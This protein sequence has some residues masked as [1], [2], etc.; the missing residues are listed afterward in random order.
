MFVLVQLLTAS[1]IVGVIPL[2]WLMEAGY[3]A[4]AL[5]VFVALALTDAIDG[6]LAR[7]YDCVSDWGK[8][9][10]PMA[11]K[12]FLLATLFVL[13]PAAFLKVEFSILVAIEAVL[14][15]TSFLAYTFPEHIGRA[16]GANRSGKYKAFGEIILTAVLLGHAVGF[17]AVSYVTA[18]L[19]LWL[20][21]IFAVFSL[22][23][24]WWPVFFPFAEDKSPIR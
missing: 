10:D 11:D 16:L 4:I 8:F 6:W 5:S 7:K 22:W 2:I 19:N 21:I 12:I 18:V 9:F 1:R 24:H 13:L 17:W 14:F 15:I 23:G 20:I 3:H